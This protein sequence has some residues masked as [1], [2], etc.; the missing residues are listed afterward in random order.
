MAKF[1]V[2]DDEEAVC[3]ALKRALAA[4]GHA[5]RVASTAEAGLSAVRDD[6]PDALFLDVRL[7]GMDGLTA[8][9]HLRDIPVIVM[10]AFGDLQTAVTAVQRGAFEYLTKPFDLD[11]ALD[12]ARRALERVTAKQ[13]VAV[14][15]TASDE[16]VGTGPAM[17]EVFKR[18]ALVAER[19]SCVLVTGESGTGKDL[20]ARALHRYSPRAAKPFIPVH[21]AAY[22]PSLVESELFGHRKGSFTGAVQNREGILALAEGGTVFLD[23]IAEIPLPVQAKLLRVLEQR[24]VLPIGGD[25]AEK[26][27]IRIIAATHQ[28]LERLVAAGAFREDLFH[29]LNVFRIH[30]PAL[31]ERR[32]DIEGLAG[33]FLRVFDKAAPALPVETIA[34]LKGRHWPGNVRELR[35]AVE[36]AVIVARGAA[37]RPDHFPEPAVQGDASDDLRRAALQW[38][39]NRLKDA[40][41][42]TDLHDQYLRQVEPPLFEEVLRRLK[43]NRQAAAQWLGLS[44]V[45]VRKK[46]GEYGLEKIGTE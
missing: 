12:A 4:R 44:R 20:V 17:Q 24:E 22:S 9:Q 5:V 31:R 35:N 10:T 6:I 16:L 39:D 32:E 34:Y 40:E 36:H 1:L 43:G 27:D 28:P 23:E 46:L 42:P 45:T 14:D 29:R 11:R 18:V 41:P 2:V 7:P 30:L 21:V 33:H 19:D 8:L 13:A 26:L 25:R 15:G 3:W 38:I 37:L